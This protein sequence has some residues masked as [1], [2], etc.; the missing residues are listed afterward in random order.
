MD[1][2]IFYYSGTGFTIKAAK[3][4][5]E[6]L[7]ENVKLTPVV[8][9]MRS[10][11]R[12]SS[13]K[14]VGLFFPMHAFGLPRAC[15]R[16]MKEYRFPKAEYIFSLVTRGGAPARMHLEINRYLKNQKRKLNAFGYATAP[17]TFDIIYKVHEGLEMRE[18]R[19]AFEDDVKKFATRVLEN[20]QFIDKGYRNRM[21]EYI[22]FP[23]LKVLNRRTGYFFLQN[24]FYADENCTGCGICSKMCLSG[25]I[26]MENGHPIW[27]KNVQCDY[28]FACL[29]LCPEKAVQVRNSKTGELER[30]FC[31]EISRSEIAN[32]KVS[33]KD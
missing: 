6:V 24:D 25:K 28:C 32:Q 14:K 8:G 27:R 22:L 11:R 21:L 33:T 2:E 18:A 19:A 29:Q 5:A 1:T 23:F 12:V 30:I 7:G 10:G 20:E 4:A 16:F 3:T 15:T 26:A 9:A 17:N 31:K 13:A